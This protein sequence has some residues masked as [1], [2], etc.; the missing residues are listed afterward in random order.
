MGHNDIIYFL[1]NLIL[2]PVENTVSFL[3]RKCITRFIVGHLKTGING[4]ICTAMN[5]SLCEW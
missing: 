2:Q 1:D 3:F 5:L 4:F